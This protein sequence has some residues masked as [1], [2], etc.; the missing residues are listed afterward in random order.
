MTSMLNEVKVALR[1]LLK[2]PGFS[3]IAIATLALAIG[4]TSAVVSL[5]NAL[6]VRP[7]SYQN[8]ASLVLIWEQFKTQGLDRI[9]VSPPEYVDLENGV[10][11]CAQIAAFDYRSFNLA[12]EGT[13]E[14]VSGAVVSP[15]L[16]S[17]LG[18]E[19]IA[20]RGFAREEQGEGHD[21]VVVISERLWKRRFNSDSFLI[22]KS[23]LLNGRSYTV[24]G[25]MPAS[26]EFPI[27]LFNVRGNQFAERVDLWKPIAFTQNELK[28]R[29]DRNYG[30]IARLRNGVT[31]QQ[32]QAELDSLIAN[33]RRQYRDNYRSGESFG[34]KIY[35]LQE[36]VVGEMRTGL[37]I[38][39]GA[40]AFVLLIAC[41]NLATML[42]ARASVR[43]RELAIRIA[44]GAG[45]WRLLRQVLTESV[46]LAVCGGTAGVI[47][48]VW[49]IEFLKRIGARTVPRLAEVNVD[50]TVLTVMAIV[51]I[52][53]GILFGLVPA[54]ASAKPE[55]TEALKEGGRGA[56]T[57]RRR[58]QIRSAL[59]IAETA[60]ALVLLVGA[61]LLMKSYVRLQ[62]VDPGFNPHNV[63][64]ME[65]SLPQMKY[66]SPGAFY[67]GTETTINFF[68]EANR[69]IA[70]LPG[71]QVS[72]AT[73]ALPLSGTNNDSSFEIEGRVS[74]NG[75]PTPDEEIRT[76]TPDYFRVLQTPLLQGRFFSEADTAQSPK[77]VIINRAF[78][79][80]YFANGDALGKRI[81]LDNPQRNP[82]WATIVGIVGDVRHRGLDV[83]PEPEYY[84]A[85]TQLPV[86]SMILAVRSAEDPRS[87]TS[88]IRREIQSIDPDEPV[89]NVRTLDTVI[90]DSVAPRRLAAVLLGVF[91]S[92]AL[93]L[94]AVGTYGVISY[95]VVQRTHEI[96]VRMALGAQRRDVLRLVVGHAVKLVGIGTVLGLI[97][98]L[99][100]TRALSTLLY[101][102]GAF[103]PGTFAIVTVLLAGVAFLASYLPALRATRADP[104]IAL[105]HHM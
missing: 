36:Q 78:A 13:P 20:G 66:P 19:P 82:K 55:L 79:Q 104:I 40:V 1:G 3:V 21:D 93:L 63:L 4:A 48:S 72:A 97:L 67:L 47:L 29:G 25:V 51:A 71:V 84:L 5:V 95:L 37:A 17:L 8:P 54:L 2:S 34:A 99:L 27:P 11:S 76:I 14:R 65:I 30:V 89:A 90:S 77:V 57:S 98:A 45:L 32:A 35:P 44:L 88:A 28:N 26:F 83:D 56:T 74:S 41:A 33:W 96:G 58:N 85:H 49:G 61:G 103:D 86:R 94:A 10:H 50:L 42:L 53:T 68:A 102:I 7:L 38:L 87:L 46:L 22:G 39:L 69:R 92:I 62:N 75:S 70:K 43:E 59:V 18:V 100:S 73:T 101:G 16:F 15:T 9:P 24:I 31:A 80:K 81:T 105:S 6:L 12:G 64:T 23:L 91:G 52:G 60:L